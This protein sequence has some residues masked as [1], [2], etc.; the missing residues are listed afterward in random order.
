MKFEPQ[1]TQPGLWPESKVD[2]AMKNMKGHEEAV[3]KSRSLYV[4]VL[5]ETTIRPFHLAHLSIWPKATFLHDLH[6]LHGDFSTFLI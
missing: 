1:I 4:R 5:V 2:L 6:A 3:A